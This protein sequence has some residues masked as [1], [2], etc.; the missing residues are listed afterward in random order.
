MQEGLDWEWGGSGGGLHYPPFWAQKSK[1]VSLVCTYGLCGL[2][3]S[4]LLEG[5]EGFTQG[6]EMNV[7]FM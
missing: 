6:K 3:S 5:D 1:R 7:S 2:D 4:S